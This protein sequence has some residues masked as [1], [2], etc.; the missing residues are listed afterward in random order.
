MATDKITRRLAAILAADMV[1]YSRL[2]ET[3]EADTIARQ[4]AYRKELIDP[5]ISEYKGR[6][7]KTT[8]DGLL[9]E[10]GSAVDA[11]A[12][13]AD[14]QRAMA[15]RGQDVPN[16]RRIAYRVGINLGEIVIDGDDIFGDG[17]NI[18]ARLEALAQP[19]GI[20]VSDAVFKNVRGKVELGFKDIGGQKVKNITEPIGSYQVLLDPGEAGATVAPD[21]RN[22]RLMVVGLGA[23]LVAVIAAGV[24]LWRPWTAPIERASA[25]RM[26]FALPAK[27]SIAVLPFANLSKDKDQGFFAD[28]ITEDIITDLSKVSGLFVVPGHSTRS[29]KGKAIKI[30][31]ISKE[32]GV[33]YVL[34]G[35]VRRAGDKLRVTA[36]LVDA[37]R[38]NHLWSA[39]YDREVKDVFAVQSDVTRRV[40]K[41]MAVTLKARERDRVFQKYVTN[42][43]AYDVWQRARAT[44]EVPTRA[45]ILKGEALFKKTIE[46]DRKFSGGYAGLSFN[47]SVKARFR[48]GKSQAEDVKLALATAKKAIEVDPD[49]AWSHIAMAGAHLAAGDHDA[50]VDAAE[51]ALAIQPGGYETNLFMGFYLFWADQ[52]ARAVKHPGDGQ[53][54][55]PHAGLS[56]PDF[57]GSRLHDG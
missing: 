3:N 1:G 13:A 36:R 40:V 28:G 45:N 2:M 49:F 9:A 23:V 50:A 46:L 57:P 33:R 26:K 6:I 54:P 17:V 5:K 52:G 18:A 29:Y 15:E 31:R 48:Y 14:M 32:L 27:P 38:G 56:R 34:N 19:G 7:F 21:R 35:S 22:R 55:E 43:E 42:I 39:R 16:D 51:R 44:V 41:A 24:F 20:C 11:V 4:K 53:H 47:H 30:R 37:I 12:C 25:K 10:F 8:G